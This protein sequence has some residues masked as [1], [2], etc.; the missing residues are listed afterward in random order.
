[1]AAVRR[2]TSGLGDGSGNAR[3]RRLEQATVGDQV[4]A[5]VQ[6]RHA[7]LGILQRRQSSRPKGVQFTW[8][9]TCSGRAADDVRGNATEGT[10]SWNTFSVLYIS[11]QRMKNILFPIVATVDIGRKEGGGVCAL[12]SG[13]SWVPI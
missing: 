8:S 9:F 5:G 10:V 7:P 3:T 12:F 4:Q 11:F 1:V 6:Q 13:G 2:R